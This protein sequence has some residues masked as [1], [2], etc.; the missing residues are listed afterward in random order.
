MNTFTLYYQTWEDLWENQQETF[1]NFFQ[2]DVL[3]AKNFYQS[4]FLSFNVFHECAHA[5]RCARGIHST[6]YEEEWMANLFAVGIVGFLGEEDLLDRIKS[7][8]D[9]ILHVH[10]PLDQRYNEDYFNL[11]YNE[12]S[13]NPGLYG[14]FQLVF[15]QKAFSYKGTFVEIINQVLSTK[16][17]KVPSLKDTYIL[18]EEPIEVIDLCKTI[19]ED[20]GLDFPNIDVCKKTTPN[21]QY[22][23][24]K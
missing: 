13:K 22:I 15:L 10:G 19:I 7:D 12:L 14:L 8:V 24:S 6:R 23:T 5:I 11:H 3:Q 18:K 4:F 1:V 9:K 16:F 21:I 20:M 17:L 2:G